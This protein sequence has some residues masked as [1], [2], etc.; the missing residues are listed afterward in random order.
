MESVENF[1]A[2]YVF[3]LLFKKRFLSI[4]FYFLLDFCYF[5]DFFIFCSFFRFLFFT[6]NLFI[7]CHSYSFYSFISLSMDERYFLSYI[8]REKVHVWFFNC[9]LYSHIEIRS[10]SEKAKYNTY[11]YI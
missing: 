8:E 4:L 3:W 10:D 7:R 6:W 5:L 1:C 9:I 11:V 2:S